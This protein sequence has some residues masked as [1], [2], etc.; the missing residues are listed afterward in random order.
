VTSQA[1]GH[2]FDWRF[3]ENDQ[4]FALQGCLRPQSADELNGCMEALDSA[5]STVKGRLYLNVRRLVRMNNVAFQAIARHLVDTCVNRPDLNIQVTTS[6]CVG[7]STRKFQALESANQNITVSEY[8]S[9]FYP[10]QTF[11]EEGGFIPILR[12]Q[13]KLTWH[14]EREILGRHGLKSGMQMADICCG[15][16]DFAVLAQKEYELGQACRAR[17]LKVEP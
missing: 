15:I 13:T 16:G 10:G 17:S 7:W 5:T 8:D 2:A 9:D 1:T 3:N 6:S 12:T 14:H 11:L 4:E